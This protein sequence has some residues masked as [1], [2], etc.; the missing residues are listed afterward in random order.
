MVKEHLSG[1][2][3]AR[4]TTETTPCHKPHSRTG[5][6]SATG[7]AMMAG[8]I[9]N[10]HIGKIRQWQGLG[11]ESLKVGLGLREGGAPRN[12]VLECA[13]RTSGGS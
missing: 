7:Q 11:A 4:N 8:F 9:W 2:G 1:G 5:M 6:G 10:M 3:G 13:Q 12:P